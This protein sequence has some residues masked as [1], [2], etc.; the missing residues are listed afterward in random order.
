MITTKNPATMDQETKQTLL[1]RFKKGLGT[2]EED[3]EGRG[4]TKVFEECLDK[5]LATGDKAFVRECLL[6]AF[7][8][9]GESRSPDG[10]EWH[11]QF[12]D[13]PEVLSDDVCGTLKHRHLMAIHESRIFGEPR[14]E[15]VNH[16]LHYLLDD[17][18]RNPNRDD[19]DDDDQY[20]NRD[21]DHDDDREENDPSDSSEW[22]RFLLD[23]RGELLGPA[24]AQALREADLAKWSTKMAERITR[25]N[26]RRDRRSRQEEHGSG[27][28]LRIR[29][30]LSGE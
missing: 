16:Y 12:W 21:D 13:S 3:E 28:D 14:V 5:A 6:L 30:V 20:P 15:E 8:G 17:D 2:M 25:R 26:R 1:E 11:D 29:R 24:E 9:W 18:D 19:D 27:V 23:V 22:V 4:G 10:G 7:A